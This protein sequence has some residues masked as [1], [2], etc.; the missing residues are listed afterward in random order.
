[1]AHSR[2]RGVLLI[3]V[4]VSALC[5]TSLAAEPQPPTSADRCAVCGMYVEK[6]K[7]WIATIVLEDGSQVFFDGPKDMFKYLLNLE[8]YKKKPGDIAQIFVTDYYAIRFIDARDAFFVSG[9]NVMGPMGPELVPIGKESD[10]KTFLED[11]A[12]K[13]ILTFGDVSLENIPK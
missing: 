9:S 4:F 3:C 1:M 5:G 8:K 12:G 6:Y 2:F 7:N 10:A 13:A 11:H